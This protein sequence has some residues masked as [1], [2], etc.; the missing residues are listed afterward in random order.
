MARYLYT[1]IEACMNTTL[2]D[3]VEIWDR[4]KESFIM[5]LKSIFFVIL[6]GFW[7]AFTLGGSVWGFLF[8]VGPNSITRLDILS[9][10]DASLHLMAALLVYLCGGGLWGWGIARLMNADV[11]SMVKTCA[12]SWAAT[13]FAFLMVVASLGNYFGGFSQI[14]FLP[15]FFHYRHYNFLLVFVPSVGIL[16]AINSYVATSKLGFKEKRK[17][18][19]MYAGLAAALGF[20]A[21]GLVLFFGFGWEVGYPHPGQS[22]MLLIFL[23]CSISAALAGG[24]AM[25]WILEKSRSRSHG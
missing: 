5:K 23:I 15:V 25:G 14:N 11:K 16:T 4:R 6:L 13:V 20:L 24:M 10:D 1:E 9:S 3:A 8:L 21:V 7:T 19:G 12:V 2:K 18:A 22:G 17:S